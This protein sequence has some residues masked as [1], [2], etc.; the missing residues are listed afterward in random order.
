MNPAQ[1]EY[2]TNNLYLASYLKARG[3]T[4]AA[5]RKDGRRSRFAFEDTAERQQFV[6]DFFN[7][8]DIAGFI[9][10]LKDLKSAIHTWNGTAPAEESGLQQRWR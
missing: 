3:L 7:D 6:S 5:V 1:S 8:K 10:A 4:L 2:E 9:H